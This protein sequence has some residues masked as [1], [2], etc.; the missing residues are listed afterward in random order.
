M[1]SSHSASGGDTTGPRGSEQ[2]PRREIR[3]SGGSRQAARTSNH[4]VNRVIRHNIPSFTYQRRGNHTTRLS[5]VFDISFTSIWMA[6]GHRVADIPVDSLGLIPGLNCSAEP[7]QL[8][9]VTA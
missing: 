9:G 3:L 8:T 2:T 4:R 7:W 6:R 5:W 1:Y